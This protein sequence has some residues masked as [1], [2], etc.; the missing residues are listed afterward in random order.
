MNSKES[1]AF[2]AAQVAMA[3]SRFKAHKLRITS[4]T[5][6]GRDR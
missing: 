2:R 1:M 6:E 4:P 3:V 5:I